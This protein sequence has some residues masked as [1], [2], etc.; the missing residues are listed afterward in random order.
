VRDLATMEEALAW[1]GVQYP[2]D[3]PRLGSAASGGE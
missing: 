1:L 2:I 3:L